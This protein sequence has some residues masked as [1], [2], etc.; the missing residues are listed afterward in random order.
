[1]GKF[2]CRGILRAMSD[3]IDGGLGNGVCRE[4]EEHLKTCRRCRF[5]VDAINY[6]I[7]LFDEWRGEDMP[8][9]AEIR[10]RDRLRAETGCYS[11]PPKGKSPAKAA[12]RR[13]VRKKASGARRRSEPGASHKRVSRTARKKAG[14]KAMR[15]K[16]PTLRK[17]S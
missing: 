15:R 13:A 1:M 16:R 2:D 4:I 10:L 3:Y 9:D 17:T 8:G 6:T 5:H 14:R 11:A 7:R 12:P